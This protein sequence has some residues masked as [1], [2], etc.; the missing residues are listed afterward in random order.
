M[1]LWEGTIMFLFPKLQEKENQ[2]LVVSKQLMLFGI[3]SQDFLNPHIQLQHVI[4]VVS[5]LDV[6]QRHMEHLPFLITLKSCAINFHLLSL[7]TPT[8]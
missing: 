7:M 2:M 3:T 5:D 4:I 6:I 8:K 1:N